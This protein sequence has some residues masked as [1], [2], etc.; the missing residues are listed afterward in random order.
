[1]TTRQKLF[2]VIAII[3]AGSLIF[4][5]TQRNFLQIEESANE[6]YPILDVGSSI[7]GTVESIYNP[8]KFRTSPFF[9]RINFQEGFKSTLDTKGYALDHSDVA[10]R[11]VCKDGALLKK[12]AGSDTVE[13]IY[14]EEVYRFLIYRD[15]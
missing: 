6:E 10:A 8:P 13:I 2:F 15:D 14:K 3:I 5:M 12:E 7:L 11:E 1:M 4:K 9:I